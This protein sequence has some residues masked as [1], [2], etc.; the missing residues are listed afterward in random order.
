LEADVSPSTIQEQRSLGQSAR[1]VH[2]RA[3]ELGIGSVDE[4]LHVHRRPDGYRTILEAVRADLVDA[5]E[6][7]L[8]NRAHVDR[9]DDDDLAEA[10]RQADAFS[11]VDAVRALVRY[12]GRRWRLEFPE[13]ARQLAP[14]VW[15]DVIQA[16]ELGDRQAL[17]AALDRH[18]PER[19]A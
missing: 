9:R 17:A 6:W 7:R 13:T 5:L 4:L 15:F 16:D 1:L 19:V 10:I 12:A 18:Y 11:A 8:A 2:A 3:I 14:L